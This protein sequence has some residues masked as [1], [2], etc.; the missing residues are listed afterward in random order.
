MLPEIT[1]DTCT[2][3]GALVRG[4]YHRWAC[5]ECGAFSA[6]VEPPAEWLD[7]LDNGVPRHDPIP[8]HQCGEVACVCPY[9]GLR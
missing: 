3:C 9:T 4:I 6:Y 2:G 5:T 7:Q 8:H 1:E